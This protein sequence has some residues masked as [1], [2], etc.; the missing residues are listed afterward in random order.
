MRLCIDAITM[1]TVAVVP[2]VLIDVSLLALPGGYHRT[3][4]DMPVP[5]LVY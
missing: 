5:M 4:S 1:L 2:N 3:G